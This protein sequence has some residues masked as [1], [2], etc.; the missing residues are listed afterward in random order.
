MQGI[1]IPI[2]RKNK[3]PAQNGTILLL[4]YVLGGLIYAYIGFAGSFGTR[5]S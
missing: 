1:F 4:S 2:L 5:R 3:T